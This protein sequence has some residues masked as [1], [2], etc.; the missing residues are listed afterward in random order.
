M[1]DDKRKMY[2][3]VRFEKRGYGAAIVIKQLT[4]T[5]AQKAKIKFIKE[6]GEHFL[7]YIDTNVSA[8][9]AISQMKHESI[10]IDRLLDRAYSKL[11]V[12]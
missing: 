1:Q 11:G 3:I 7:Y 6:T 2:C 10:I 5:D 4:F 8:K 12:L 9:E